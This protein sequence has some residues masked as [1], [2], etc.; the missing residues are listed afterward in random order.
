MTF[1]KRVALRVALRILGEDPKNSFNKDEVEKWLFNNFNNKGWIN[2]YE[3]RNIK[4]L[5]EMGMGVGEREYAVLVGRRFELLNINDD[6]RRA[7]ENRKTADEKK[8]AEKEIKE[9]KVRPS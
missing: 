4:L 1:I 9:R 3:Y 8:E 5:K 7:A 6:M 2:Y